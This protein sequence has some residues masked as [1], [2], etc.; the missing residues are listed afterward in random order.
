MP[1]ITH[2]PRHYR[3]LLTPC[4]R[5]QRSHRRPT[6]KVTSRPPK[7]TGSPP[8]GA[9]GSRHSGAAEQR[10]NQTPPTTTQACGTD[11]SSS[12]ARRGRSRRGAQS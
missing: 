8:T 6:S 1:L 10:H 2:G 4:R 12:S 9:T 7:A 3:L 5:L 11:G